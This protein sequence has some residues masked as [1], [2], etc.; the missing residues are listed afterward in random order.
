MKIFSIAVALALFSFIS[1]VF[2][3]Q[4]TDKPEIPAPYGAVFAEVA[5][6][7]TV[8]YRPIVEIGRTADT[9]L[10]VPSCLFDALDAKL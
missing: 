9:A 7:V 1:P 2:G 3:Q 5:G 6:T 10:C 8:G 4:P